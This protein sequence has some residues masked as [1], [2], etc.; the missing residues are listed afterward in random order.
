MVVPPLAD[1]VDLAVL[2]AAATVAEAVL[3]EPVFLAEAVFAAVREVVVVVAGV[4]VVVTGV[5]LLADAADAPDDTGTVVAP[6]TP[7]A[8]ATALEP[9]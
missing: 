2:F 6:M 8:A 1:F 7:S 9:A 5:G 3:A 4:V